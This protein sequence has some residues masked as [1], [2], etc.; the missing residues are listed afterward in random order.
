MHH[1]PLAVPPH[2][3]DLWQVTTL[4][5]A[6]SEP[7]RVQILLRLIIGELSVSALVE[8]LAVPQSTVSRH[9]NVLRGA[10]LVQARRDGTHVYYQLADTHLITLLQEAFSHAQH[11]RLGLPDHPQVETSVG[12]V[13]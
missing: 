11:T 10:G 6:L 13:H 2:S 1:H 8:A 9:L 7:I 4:F 12:S 3:D 5:K